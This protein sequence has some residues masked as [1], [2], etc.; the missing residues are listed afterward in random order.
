VQSNTRDQS[1]RRSPT[2]SASHLAGTCR[3]LRASADRRCRRR[4]RR[5]DQ[6]A[7]YSIY[8][9]VDVT[10]CRRRLGLVHAVRP[11]PSVRNACLET[12]GSPFPPRLDSRQ[13]AGVSPESHVM[14][15]RRRPMP[16]YLSAAVH[17]GLGRRPLRALEPGDGR[18][19]GQADVCRGRTGYLAVEVDLN[20][21]ER[22]ADGWSVG[23]S[24]LRLAEARRLTTA[25]P[26]G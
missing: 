12:V 13:A 10:S 19:N 18:T 22:P 11:R 7:S 6:E 23:R 21:A 25:V 24:E 4:Q 14:A 2:S 9:I 20:G 1:P 16:I 26:G 5:I 3:E 8:V 15:P 17:A